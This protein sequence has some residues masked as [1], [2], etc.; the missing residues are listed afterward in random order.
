MEVKV[1]EDDDDDDGGDNNLNVLQ[2]QIDEEDNDENEGEYEL[3]TTID[4]GD[5]VDG[6]EIYGGNVVEEAMIEYTDEE[7]PLD[8]DEIDLIDYEETSSL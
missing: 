1:D 8:D 6:G 4:D 3:I 7:Q 2:Q 5:V